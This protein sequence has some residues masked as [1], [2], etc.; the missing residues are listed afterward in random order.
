MQVVYHAVMAHMIIEARELL[1]SLRFLEMRVM[2][3][4][5]AELIEDYRL[6]IETMHII[7][8]KEGLHQVIQL[9]YAKLSGIFHSTQTSSQQLT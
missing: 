6:C 5:L 9:L 4:Q 8:N 7:N 3:G 2:F 1:C